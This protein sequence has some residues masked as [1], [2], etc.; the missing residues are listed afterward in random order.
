MKIAEVIPL[1]KG[2]AKYLTNNYRPISLLIT[3]SKILEKIVYKRTYDHLEHNNQLYKSQYGFHSK[4]SCKNAVSELVGDIF[5]ANDCN[6]YTVSV[7]LDLSK[8]FDT[9]EHS[10]LFTKLNKYGIRGTC[11]DWFKS[12]LHERSLR[13][14]C[15]TSNAC[16][17]I[18][19]STHQVEYGAPQGSCLGPLLF[20]IF[21]NDL[22]LNLLHT[23]CILFADDATLYINRKKLSFAKWCMEEDLKTLHDWFNANKLTLNLN[24]TVSMLFKRNK[25]TNKL[26][27][28]VGNITIPQVPE[29]KFLGV[30]LDSGLNWNKHINMLETKV[31]QNKYL[32]QCS[33]NMLDIPTKCLVYFSH[34]YSHLRYCILVGK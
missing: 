16:K 31:K 34:I 3:V 13:I 24:K 28:E 30:W 7:F 25:T 21:T 9:L 33:S 19:S 15:R 1:H 27:L 12:Y 14:K 23:N 2:K 10:I 26:D 11:L 6:K 32:L 8:A 5:K 29:T 4:H 20:L 17:E 22:Y 18:K